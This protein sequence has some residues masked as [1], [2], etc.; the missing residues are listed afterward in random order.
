MALTDDLQ[1]KVAEIF[2][3]SWTERD[4]TTVPEPS[5][6]KLTNDAVK[7]TGTVL[8][9]DMRES[10]ALVDTKTKRFAAEIY[11]TYLHCAAKIITSEGGVITSYDGDRIMAVF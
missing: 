7:L 2:K 9:A 1:A 10:T 4:G 3:S 8:Y 6:L 11:K 5:A